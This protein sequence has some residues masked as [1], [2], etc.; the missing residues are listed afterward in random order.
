MTE[1]I[2]GQSVLA[3]RISVILHYQA[4][5]CNNVVNR[6][7]TYL[8][9]NGLE[10][11]MW[12]RPRVRCLGSLCSTCELLISCWTFTSLPFLGVIP[13]DSCHRTRCNN[14]WFLSHFIIWK[15]WYLDFPVGVQCSASKIP[16]WLLCLHTGAFSWAAAPVTV[17]ISEQGSGDY[18]NRLRVQLHTPFCTLLFIRQIP[19][20]WDQCI[21]YIILEQASYI[22]KKI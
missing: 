11:W 21:C 14:I 13:P 18:T 3:S 12:K 10:S 6:C 8:L 4:L 16:V 22:L 20:V 15:P 2:L 7:K 19:S 17:Q 1:Y 5:Y 9:K